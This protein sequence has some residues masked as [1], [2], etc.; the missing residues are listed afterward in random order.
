MSPLLPSVH[1]LQELRGTARRC[2]RDYGETQAEAIDAFLHM[3]VAPDRQRLRYAG[4][5]W[6]MLQQWRKPVPEFAR[7][8][9]EGA[10]LPVEEI[11]LLLLHEE[12]V[13]TKPCTALGATRAGTKDGRPIIGQNWDWNSYLYPWSSLLR[14]RSDDGP[15]ALHYAYPGLWA[16]AGINEH[17]LSLVWTGAGYLPKI[18]PIVGIP[19]YA[20]IAG[21]LACKDCAKALALLRR[22]VNAGCFVFFIA[23]AA[24]E[25]WVIEGVPGRMEMV[26]ADDV[27]TR[28]NHYECAGIA[29]RARQNLD[30]IENPLVSTQYRGPRMAAL[31]Q[32][33]CGKINRHVMER[34]LRDE[35]VGDGRN[36]CGRPKGTRRGLAID[37]FY[38]LPVQREFW[39]ARGI[40][41]RHA[42]RRYRV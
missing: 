14:L 10:R 28:A 12:I 6:E 39:I 9:A 36:I 16:A 18:K 24:G 29:R 27:I 2:G 22:T 13:H 31:A 20:L 21:L 25:V 41:T 17:G 35:G 4:R 7:G 19:T 1:S 23:D 5:C 30:Q 11:T 32:R 38:C 40:Q 15:A 37:S 33:F 26:R 8:I 3:E 42:Y 34:C